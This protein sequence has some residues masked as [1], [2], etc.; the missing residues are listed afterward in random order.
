MT[1]APRVP[2][3][4][5]WR[6]ELCVMLSLRM[7]RVKKILHIVLHHNEAFAFL[8]RHCGKEKADARREKQR[9]SDGVDVGHTF[10]YTGLSPCMFLFRLSAQHFLSSLDIDAVGGTGDATAL[11]IVNG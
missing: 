7:D 3:P 4:R 2:T 1:I 10:D 6:R 9:A 11:E 5:T 8:L